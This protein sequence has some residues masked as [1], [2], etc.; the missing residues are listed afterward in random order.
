MSW[1]KRISISLVPYFA[2]T[3]LMLCRAQSHG[4]KGVPLTTETRWGG[5]ERIE[6]DLRDKPVRKVEGDVLGPGEGTMSTLVQVFRRQPSD[7]LYQPPSQDRRLPIAA[8]MTGT[9]GSFDFSLSP[10]EYELLMSQ[11]GGVDVTSVFITVRRGHY[12]SKK[13]SVTM[14][15]GT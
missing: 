8:C 5:N 14:H 3:T 9:D 1:L 12:R 13:I 11:N 6:I 15:V 4:C 10:G 2:L 7:P